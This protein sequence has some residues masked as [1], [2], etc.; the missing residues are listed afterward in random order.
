MAG[1]MATPE[2]IETLKTEVNRL[3]RELRAFVAVAPLE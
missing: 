3:N 2:T 1:A